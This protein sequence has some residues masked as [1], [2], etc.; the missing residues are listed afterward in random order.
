MKDSQTSPQL[1]E[2]KLRKVWSKSL[3]WW[4][5][6]GKGFESPKI[7]PIPLITQPISAT[8]DNFMTWNMPV[9]PIS[10]QQEHLPKILKLTVF[11]INQLP[12]KYEHANWDESL[13]PETWGLSHQYSP[14]LCCASCTSRAF[15][16]GS[17]MDM[18]ICTLLTSPGRRAQ[19]SSLSK[20]QKCN[21]FFVFYLLYLPS[22]CIYHTSHST[23]IIC[24]QGQLD[25]SR[26]HGLCKSSVTST[27]HKLCFYIN[28][29]AFLVRL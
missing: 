23:P 16:P 29:W 4:K 11:S 27:L 5:H 14:S 18:S 25:G 7:T 20:K 24:L 2:L 21:F 8:L 10:L 3:S 19:Q 12:V 28:I 1:K 9:K 26:T 22:S 6:F 15:S 13:F 17:N